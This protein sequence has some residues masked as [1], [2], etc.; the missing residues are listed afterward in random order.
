MLS[1]SKP[2]SAN[3]AE[4]YYDRDEYYL[5]SKGQWS[6][7]LAQTLRLKGEIK[8]EDFSCFLRGF[9]RQ[10]TKLV[11]SAGSI[12]KDGESIHRSGIDL[13]FSAP[14]SV[15][16]LSYKD[17]N[18]EK[19][20]NKSVE[21]AL[22]HIEENFARTR[23]KDKNKISHVI[24]SDKLLFAKF[25]HRTS[26]ELDPQLHTH[27][28]C[29]NI[30]NGEMGKF[31]TMHNDEIYLNKMYLGQYFR[32]E[33]NKNIQELGYKTKVSDRKNGFWEIDGIEDGIL[34]ELSKRSIQVED[35]IKRLKKIKFIDLD[36][37]ILRTFAESN[38][39]SKKHENNFPELLKEEVNRLK[40]SD[41][42]V[43][44]NYSD[45]M[46]HDLAVTGTRI[47][48]K[49]VTKEK[50]VEQIEATCEKYSTTLDDLIYNSKA[51][52]KVEKNIISIKKIM[53]KSIDDLTEMESAFGKFELFKHALK[54]GLNHYTL[55]EVSSE[56][57]RLKLNGEIIHLG[58]IK[59]NAG[60][61]HY[62]TSDVMKQT[63]EKIIQYC[64]KGIGENKIH[65]DKRSVEN[66]LNNEDLKLKI[67]TSLKI[68]KDVLN[69]ESLIDFERES[70][71]FISSLNDEK[72]ELK[73]TK[74]RKHLISFLSDQENHD[75]SV[76]ILRYVQKEK[77]LF[78]YIDTH[79]KGFTKGQREAI[80][81]ITLSKCNY[82]VIQGDA[83]TGKSFSMLYAKKMMES[84]DFV[85]KGF[86]PTGKAAEELNKS[87]EIEN[88]ST[89]DSFL[90]KFEN[91][92]DEKKQKMFNHGKECWIID[93]AGMCGAKKV[94]RLMEAAKIVGAKVVFVGDRKQFASIEAGKIFS[95]LQDKTDIDITTMEDVMRQKTE[96]T[97]KVVALLKDKDIDNTF[98]MLK[99]FNEI[100]VNNTHRFKKDDILLFTKSVNDIDERSVTYIKSKTDDN[101][102]I[103]TIHNN[104]DNTKREV[105]FDPEK[106]RNAYKAYE[107]TYNNVI[108]ELSDRDKRLN[109]ICNDYFD[110]QSKNIDTMVITGTNK[111]R[112][113]LNSLIRSK[114]VE[115]EKIGESF[116]FNVFESANIGGEKAS[117]ADSYK[118]GQIIITTNNIAGIP[119]GTQAEIL[120]INMNDNSL[121]VKFWD[122]DDRRYVESDIDVP[123]SCKRFSAFS[124]QD[125]RFGKGEK[126]VFLKNDKKLGVQNG[127][128]GEILNINNHGDAIVRVGKM[129][130]EFNISN[131]GSSAYNYIDHAYALSE[132]KSQGATINRLIWHAPTNIGK[133]STNSFYVAATRCT[134]SLSVY[135]DDTSLLQEKVKSE[136]QKISTLDFKSNIKSKTNLASKLITKIDPG[137]SMI[138]LS[139]D[140]LKSIQESY[141]NNKKLSHDQFLSVLAKKAELNG[142]E[143]SSK[144]L[145]RFKSVLNSK[146][147]DQEAIENYVDK[148]AK[149]H[150]EKGLFW[151]N[152]KESDKGIE[153]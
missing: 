101:K 126:I 20:F 138:K 74:F 147:I 44:K 85:V 146:S 113:S 109:A 130:I 134:N 60:E 90:L 1:I 135:T 137:T 19:A 16:I 97:K 117:F 133:L 25:S 99:G 86:A 88:C 52:K 145:K 6:G 15:S 43:Y 119:R 143:L 152:K 91:S 142:V 62:F 129:N 10:G 9:D 92:D 34:N 17:T 37:K 50:I 114:L 106:N 18:I 3:S 120:S 82:S 53:Q 58:G 63:E 132:Y 12:N 127:Q 49:E 103:L 108:S 95:E 148:A 76:K 81:Q 75:I 84:N 47:A 128:I 110:S 5:D 65:L 96:Q 150:K 42:L 4:K 72:L 48:K 121:R 64:E 7:R 24:E 45:A 59:H 33:L 29:F 131:K 26:R 27:C 144:Q 104:E 68:P 70:N 102:L 22:S 38:L 153:I 78:N 23:F 79:G 2:L 122:K 73:I 77:E 57:E 40:N 105:E 111:D 80:S 55:N 67:K 31:K 21:K 32:N 66:I 107:R 39:Q 11:A 14:K 136:Q 124:V 13:T 51:D 35:E 116:L 115:L 140:K 8:R 125:K 56:F 141:T 30:T 98:R 123:K 112:N 28:V 87:A 71:E 41:T 69:Q 89:I 94:L 61:K 36:K 83:G 46:L 54:M 139:L 151:K 100:E 93:E 149:L 118:P